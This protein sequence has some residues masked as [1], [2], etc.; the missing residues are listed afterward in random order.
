MNHTVHT[1]QDQN[2]KK[3]CLEYVLNTR[4]VLIDLKGPKHNV[5]VKRNDK[6]IYTYT[7]INIY[8]K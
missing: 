5:C 1:V 4:N 3:H 8:L 7:L 6:Q 2:S